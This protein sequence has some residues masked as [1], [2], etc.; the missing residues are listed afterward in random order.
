M[1]H[2]LTSDPALA[3]IDPARVPGHVA[4]IMDGNGRWAQKR[5]LP[6][7]Q[8][9]RRGVEALRATLRAAR[10]MGIH[11]LTLYSFSSENW[12]RPAAEVA[13]LMGLLKL[14]IRRD[15][16]DLHKE[17]VRVRVIGGRD[18]LPS[19]ILPLIEDA[20]R[21]TCG[22]NGQTLVLAFN[23]GGRGEIARAA[24]R[25]SQAVLDGVLSPAEICETTVTSYLDT[26]GLPEPDLLIRTGGEQRLSNFLLFQAAYSE[27]V[28]TDCLW[29]D[30][31][32]QTLQRAVVE[33]QSRD[34]RFG[35]V[36]E[37]LPAAAT[38]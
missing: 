14:F 13:D 12:S 17:N 38:A 31:D 32:L 25:M 10:T 4:I 36:P 8:G 9:H 37:A 26:A 19:D 35:G 11:T 16:A 15:L 2:D 29:P 20:E 3:R 28:F 30:F 34:R 18:D 21:V 22:N 24:V 1:Q 27:L 33:F 5:G 6:R 7:T 23:Y